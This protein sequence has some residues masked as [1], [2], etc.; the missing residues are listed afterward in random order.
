MNKE[1]NKRSNCLPEGA[2]GGAAIGGAAQEPGAAGQA[3]EG[4]AAGA[5]ELFDPILVP[6]PGTVG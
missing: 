6:R 3:R 5:G 2:G 4:E 1:T